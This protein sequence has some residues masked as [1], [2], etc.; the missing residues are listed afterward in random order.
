MTRFYFIN[1]LA[2]VYLSVISSPLLTRDRPRDLTGALSALALLRLSRLWRIGSRAVI[3]SDL[4][5]SGSWLLNGG[6]CP[7][8]PRKL[9]AG[10]PKCA[11]IYKVKSQK[12]Q[13]SFTLVASMPS[14]PRLNGDAGI[15]LQR[16]V[17][18]MCLRMG[19]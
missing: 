2:P 19:Y 3:R 6:S 10:N 4:S 7:Q 5:S 18:L 16:M 13:L 12:D 9:A 17:C 1:R 11:L 8:K 14:L 15:Q